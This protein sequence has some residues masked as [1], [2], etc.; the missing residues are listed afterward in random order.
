[1]KQDDAKADQE[2][3]MKNVKDK[4]IDSEPTSS[5]LYAPAFSRTLAL[6]LAAPTWSVVLSWTSAHISKSRGQKLWAPRHD[7]LNNFE[8]ALK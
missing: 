7:L 4:S 3:D 8:E 5:S 1:M 2:K 6:G